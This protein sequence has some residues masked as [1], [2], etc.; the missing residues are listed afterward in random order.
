MVNRKSKY[1]TNKSVIKTNNS[2]FYDYGQQEYVQTHY[3]PLKIKDEDKVCIYGKKDSNKFKVYT[4][5]SHYEIVNKKEQRK[6]R[7]KGLEEDKEIDRKPKFRV[8]TIGVVAEEVGFYRGFI[9]G[10]QIPSASI[11]DEEY[12][13]QQKEINRKLQ[14]E[15]RRIFE[16]Q[17]NS[18][19]FLNMPEDVH[20]ENTEKDKAIFKKN[21][22]KGTLYNRNKFDSE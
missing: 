2:N 3:G 4:D 6:K 8:K 7:N 1:N 12:E 5:N 9:N 13:L 18:N 10:L 22:E 17:G 14:K 16:F 21:G 20:E 15:K 11:E 19:R